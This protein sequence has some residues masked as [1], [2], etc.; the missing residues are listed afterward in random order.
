MKQISLCLGF[1]LLTFLMACGNE[2]V[3]KDEK[4]IDIHD[5]AKNQPEVHGT[6][7]KEGDITFGNP[8]NNDWVSVGKSTYELKC[9]SCHRLSEVKLVGP[10]WKGVTQSRKPRVFRNGTPWRLWTSFMHN[11][12]QQCSTIPFEGDPFLR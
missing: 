10:G 4:P 7:I 12:I 2:G 8:L 1:L 3:R 6:E 5:L 9:M 11:L